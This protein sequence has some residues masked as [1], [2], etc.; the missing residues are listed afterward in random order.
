MHTFKRIDTTPGYPWHVG[1]VL[2]HGGEVWFD[3][4]AAFTGVNNAIRFASFLNGGDDEFNLEY[5]IEA[6]MAVI[7]GDQDYG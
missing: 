7:P 6:K 3:S 4:K 5:M 1:I 2:K